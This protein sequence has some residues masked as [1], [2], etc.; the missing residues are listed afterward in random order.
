MK[1]YGQRFQSGQVDE[2]LYHR[3]F[4]GKKNGFFIEC[5]SADGLNLSS[6][7][8]F[9]E[10][11]GWEG[12]NMEASPDKFA[13]L[14]KNRPNSWLNLNKGLLHEAGT[15]VFRDDTVTDPTKYPGWGNGSFQHT[16]KHYIQLH[17]MG[18]QLK[19]SEIETITFAQLVD[20]L[21]LEEIDLFVLDVEGMELEVIEGM[22]GSSVLP[23]IMFVEHEHVGLVETAR[24]LGELG[25]RMDWNDFC[26][27]AYI[28]E[29]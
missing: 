20:D 14:V 16:E 5:G 12:I 27:S 19:E 9:E 8:F 22:K 15:F 25:Y 7:K 2:F 6:C 4:R 18:V 17:Q 1:Y 10:S 23:K 29:K 11:M 21:E 28:L 13:E 24:A 3:Y 26:N